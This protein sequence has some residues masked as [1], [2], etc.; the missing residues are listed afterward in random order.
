[1]LNVSTKGKFKVTIR[2]STDKVKV[3]RV[4]DWHR[5]GQNILPTNPSQITAWVNANFSPADKMSFDVTGIKT[6]GKDGVNVFTAIIRYGGSSLGA[7]DIFILNKA[8]KNKF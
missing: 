4:F 3:V 2:N 1:M 6:V 5:S 8:D 7:S